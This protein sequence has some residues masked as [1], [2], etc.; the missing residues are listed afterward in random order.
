[1]STLTSFRPVSSPQ[2][3]NNQ[4]NNNNNN[5]KQ[6][7]SSSDIKTMIFE[8]PFSAPITPPSESSPTIMTTAQTVLRAQAQALLFISDLYDQDSHTQSQFFLSLQY[9]HNAILSH[10]KIVI[11]GMGKS[12]K[13]AEKLVA[14]MNSLGIH[15]SSLHP[16]D[17]L[18]G[19]LGVIKPTDVVVMITAS[20]NTPELLAL[21]P[22]IP[23]GI[24]LLILTN[25]PDSPLAKHGSATLSAFIP[26]S[27]S[28]KAVYGLP[29]PTTSTTA[30]LAVG[31]AV[32]ITLAEMLV[33]DVK[34]RSSNFSKWHPGG[35]IGKDYKKE[36]KSASSSDTITASTNNNTTTSSSTTNSESSTK[37]EG[38]DN[39][40]I[41]DGENDDALNYERRIN[42]I[43][44]RTTPWT[45]V[46]HI[47]HKDLSS[48]LSLLRKCAARDWV[49]VDSRYLIQTRD[50]FYVLEQY[51][52]AINSGGGDDDSTT[53]T[54]SVSLQ[55][56]FISSDKNIEKH[57]IFMIHKH[58]ESLLE[59]FDISNIGIALLLDSKGTYSGLYYN[60]EEV[61][62]IY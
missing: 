50:I 43:S 35:A 60:G 8:S 25:T 20:G 38:D 30:C 44:N 15:A 26:K 37:I 1:M 18:H 22:H 19:D 13:I 45:R 54:M 51:N 49:L 27:L 14:T 29:A 6:N 16:S 36:K 41:S 46:G 11:T 32:C 7:N 42:L 40:T 55:D 59:S 12:F 2:S 31:D 17:A 48:E 33:S 5:S 39:S 4:Y 34:Q 28:E 24:P 23:S 58:N 9:M 57:D 10:G 62:L 61:G 56:F 52:D 53:T 47:S 3:S 21:L